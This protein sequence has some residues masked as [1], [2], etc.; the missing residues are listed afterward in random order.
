VIRVFTLCLFNF[1]FIIFF[2]CIICLGRRRSH[3]LINIE[4]VFLNLVSWK[5]FYTDT[6]FMIVIFIITQGYTCISQVTSIGS[7]AV[8]VS[9]TL[10]PIFSHSSSLTYNTITS[11]SWHD[12]CRFCLKN[13]LFFKPQRQLSYYECDVRNW[14]IVMNELYGMRL[15]IGNNMLAIWTHT[16]DTIGIYVSKIQS[17]N[18]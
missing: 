3:V 18:Y 12:C 16:D 15:K 4:K 8:H 13:N 17:Y 6:F 10:L 7:C 2:L 14:R 11:H 1:G 5:F 9:N